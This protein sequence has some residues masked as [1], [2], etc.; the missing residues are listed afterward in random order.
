M[1]PSPGARGSRV[2]I[3]GSPGTKLAASSLKVLS[4]VR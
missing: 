4:E 3:P 1:G 2:I